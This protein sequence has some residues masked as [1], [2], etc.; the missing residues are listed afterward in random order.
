MQLSNTE[1]AGEVQVG[2]DTEDYTP[3]TQQV[4]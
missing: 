1:E 3:A 2:V 4:C